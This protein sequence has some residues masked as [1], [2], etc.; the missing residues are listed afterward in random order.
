MMDRPARF[1][2]SALVA[3][4]G[5]GGGESGPTAPA[6]TSP[7]ITS[8]PQDVTVTE[9]TAASFSVTAS[10]SSP[11]TYQ[12][13]RN[14][15]SIAGAAASTYS[16]SSATPADE[17]AE[18]SVVVS[19]SAGS[20]TSQPGRLTVRTPVRLTTQPQNQS[21]LSGVPA[22]FSVTATGTTPS[23]QWNRN[24]APIPGATASTYAVGSPFAGDDGAS[25]SVV[26][27]NSLGSVASGNAVLAVNSGNG[28]RPSSYAN[29]KGSNQGPVTVPT[30]GNGRAFGDFFGSGNRDY[31][32]ATLVYDAQKPIAEAQPG[33][34]QFWRWTGSSFTR[35]LAKVD[36]A[37]G[38]LHPRKAAVADFNGDGRPDIFV[39]CHGYDASP[40]PGEANHVL[41]S[42]PNGIYSNRAVAGGTA[43]FYHSVTAFDVNGDTHVDVVV[44]NHFAPKAVQ[45]FLNDGH[46]TFTQRLDLSPALAGPYF[47]VE[48]ADV[49]GDN[50]LDLLAG[51][52]DWENA[53]TV[54]L[55]ANSSGSFASAAPQVVPRVQ[56]EG[57][58]LDFVV[59]DSDRNGVNEIYVVRTSGGDGTFYQSRTV[60][61][62]AW[63][64]LTSSVLVSD[65]PA[66]WIDFLV[67]IF[68]GSQ[69]QLSSDNTTMPFSMVLP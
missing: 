12:W 25:Y 52:H 5:C 41:L 9:G 57:V 48:A 22:A 29:A 49:D 27:T 61:R 59:L 60:Q 63:P 17:G 44:T 10:G 65:R 46:G 2:S 23:Y 66:P 8:H 37:T 28:V 18:F 11:L 38:C 1:V 13:R 42:Q 55:L 53:E 69:Y 62:V 47:T 32:I 24:G 64:S 34:F 43:G 56:N 3:L 26:V 33:E 14:G 19:N 30:F 68:A 45:V 4:L 50:R 39:A 15:A 6:P 67:P 16:I 21:V 40:F 20:V 31:F 7:T 58:V 51:G 35:D 36:V 54:V